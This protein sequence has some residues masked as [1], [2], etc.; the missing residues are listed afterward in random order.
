[1]LNIFEYITLQI[2]FFLAN[3]HLHDFFALWDIDISLRFTIGCL[4]STIKVHFYHFFLHSNQ[5][6]QTKIVKRKKAFNFS[7]YVWYS[8]R[9]DSLCYVLQHQH[10]F[11]YI[12]WC[13]L[14]V[15]RWLF[16]LLLYS[17]VYFTES[18]NIN[19]SIIPVISQRIFLHILVKN[20]LYVFLFAFGYIIISIWYK[21]HENILIV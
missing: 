1:M 10:C 4:F 13:A 11:F 12:F 5:T 16:G 6:Y 7:K 9:I 15:P 2:V 21:V 18:F 8:H 3:E 20:L 14:I 19:L 17:F